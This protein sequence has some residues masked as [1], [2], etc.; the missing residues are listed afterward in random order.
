MLLC[1]PLSS[2]QEETGG[3]AVRMEWFLVKITVI[4]TLAKEKRPTSSSITISIKLS[5]IKIKRMIKF[6]FNNK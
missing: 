2:A 6:Y 5:I 4:L 3:Q 1:G